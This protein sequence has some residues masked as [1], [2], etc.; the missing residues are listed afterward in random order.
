[1]RRLIIPM[2][3]LLVLGLS[4]QAQA[5]SALT[6]L[7][8]YVVNELEDADYES[9]IIGD[10]NLV[11]VDD[12]LFGMFAV[13]EWVKT[14]SGPNAGDTRYPTTDTFV[15]M[16]VT[17]VLTAVE[18][19]DGE[20]DYTF[21]AAEDAVWSALTGGALIPTAA[22]GDT[23]FIIFDDH[24]GPAWVNPHLGTPANPVPALATSFNGDELWEL[25]FHD[26]NSDLFWTAHAVSN[27]I[28][29]IIDESDLTTA[30]A[31]DV[32]ETT[33][34]VPLLLH[35]TRWSDVWSH[36]QLTGRN[37]FDFQG[38]S[39]G[40]FAL[41]TDTEMWVVPTP[42]P[43]TFALLGLGLAGFGAAV[44]RRRRKA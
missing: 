35:N 11:G 43:G 41:L 25:G 16:F 40:S 37:Q 6:L 36:V 22:S 31:L 26:G 12:Y 18:D 32:L 4:I 34:G 10:D 3:V 1:M 38:Q 7:E 5:G 28:T 24:D 23:M 19:T 2:A 14:L 17:K 13:S 9:G 30:A 42:E 8:P 15:G 33:G 21:G 29:Q 44:I 20:W 27:D 39:S